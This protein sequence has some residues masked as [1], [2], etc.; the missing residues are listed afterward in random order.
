MPSSDNILS[1]LIG[2]VLGVATTAVGGYLTDRFTDRRCN[3]E[4]RRAAAKRFSQVQALMPDLIIELRAGV[5]ASP[6]VRVCA[7]VPSP[8]TGF[9]W[10]A[11][12]FKYA[13]T[14]HD[15]LRGKFTV[16]AQ[17]GYVEERFDSNVPV[18][19]LT[20]EFVSALTSRPGFFTRVFRT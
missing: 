1:G 2:F 12:H 3:R 14:E 20:E 17:H 15:N 6:T 10:P 13:E 7:L 16:L 9:N 8:A 19:H 18:F 5:I 4:E 11:P